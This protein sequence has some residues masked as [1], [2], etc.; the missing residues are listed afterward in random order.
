MARWI[1]TVSRMLGH[2]HGELLQRGRDVLRREARSLRP[3]M[4]D[5]LHLLA[6]AHILQT[7]RLMLLTSLLA[8]AAFLGIRLAL[9]HS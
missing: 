2:R 8:L 1:A 5:P 6:P 4:G 3:R 9:F 7:N